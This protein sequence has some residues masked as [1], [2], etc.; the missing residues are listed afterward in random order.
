MERTF[1]VSDKTITKIINNQLDIKLGQFTPE[2][3]NVVLIKI[4]YRKAAGHDEI[5]PEVWKTKKFNDLLLQYYN[6]VYNQNVIERWTKGCILPFTKKGDLG[7]V[8][9]TRA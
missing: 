1:Q 2:E 8:R 3:L 6:T 7:I 9:T 4:K 5:L